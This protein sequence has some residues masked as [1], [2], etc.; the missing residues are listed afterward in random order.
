MATT[1]PPLQIMT[2]NQ[3]QERHDKVLAF[4]DVLHQLMTNEDFDT[5]F[6]DTLVSSFE[7]VKGFLHLEG[8]T[9]DWLRDLHNDCQDTGADFEL[10]SAVAENAFADLAPYFRDPK[11]RELAESYFECSGTTEV[12]DVYIQ[13]R[14]VRFLGEGE[15]GPA[16][17]TLLVD[18]YSTFKDLLERG[19]DSHVKYTHF[20]ERK[21]ENP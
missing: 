18:S 6:A 15:A 21:E 14:N 2:K 8:C 13:Q 16:V 12:S 20:S 3:R 10:V 5:A 1:L 19:E 4:Y 9:D 11:A 17:V 7:E